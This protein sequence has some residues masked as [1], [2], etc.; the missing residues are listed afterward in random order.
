MRKS[1]GKASDAGP[2][3]KK[4]SREKERG[5]RTDW[6]NMDCVDICALMKSML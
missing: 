3:D 1:V 5:G 2:E 4:V 6:M